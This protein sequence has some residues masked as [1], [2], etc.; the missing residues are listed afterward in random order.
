[1]HKRGLS[2]A[3]P[4]SRDVRCDRE[5][6]RER[7]R[8]RGGRD[9]FY[10]HGSSGLTDSALLGLPSF[11][12][13]ADPSLPIRSV[14]L[15]RSSLVPSAMHPPDRKGKESESERRKERTERIVGACFVSFSLSPC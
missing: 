1:V 8:E 13:P 11:I 10:I 14:L 5:R 7:E 15:F 6:K 4:P 9:I 2:L 12:S 3:S